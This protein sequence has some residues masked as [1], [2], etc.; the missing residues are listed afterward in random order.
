MG[1][2]IKY[3]K[4]GQPLPLEQ[5]SMPEELKDSQQILEASPDV[6]AQSETI[7]TI[8]QSRDEVS[9]VEPE[10][11]VA[12]EYKVSQE[13]QRNIRYM[14]ERAELADRLE[15]ERDD[16][17]RQLAEAKYKPQKQEAPIEDDSLGLGDNDLA[18]GKHLSKVD[19][20]VKALKKELAQYKQ[21]TS[22]QVTEA[23]IKTQFP[24]FDNI[25]SQE[26]IRALQSQYPEIANTLN[27]STDLY[28]TAVSAYTMIK[29]LGIS[30]EDAYNS[31]KARALNN[32]AKPRPVSSVSSNSGP[33]S[34]ANAFANGLTEDL[35]KQLQKEMFAARNLI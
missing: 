16:L 27:S 3:S 5:Q 12:Q 18:E 7:Q 10:A 26:N 11:Q 20:E 33:L 30:Q 9:R 28:S 6:E 19:R 14:R 29:K 23:R 24:D 8:D 2:E 15:R 22:Q 35:K 1:F 34:Q 13:N 25:V 4:D 32:L 17:A 31:D 21:Q